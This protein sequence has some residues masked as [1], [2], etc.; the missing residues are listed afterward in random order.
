MKHVLVHDQRDNVGVAVTNIK[1]GETVTGGA[2]GGGP[3]FQI[4]ALQDIP[5]GHKIALKELKKGETAIKYGEDIGRV[6]ADTQ[7]GGHVHVHNL[8]TKRW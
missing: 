2:L 8:K 7:T 5:L 3:A 6:V 4:T 1:S